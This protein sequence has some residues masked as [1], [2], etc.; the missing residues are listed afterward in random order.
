[1]QTITGRADAKPLNNNLEVRSAVMAIY[2]TVR[3]FSLSLDQFES[4]YEVDIHSRVLHSPT[5]VAYGAGLLDA[6]VH[7]IG[8]DLCE[9]VCKGADGSTCKGA[10]GAGTA[11]RW[12]GTDFLFVGFKEAL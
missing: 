11:L 7:T 4:L 6:L 2:Q 12:K 9:V 8:V 1:M 10:N 5:L 3:N